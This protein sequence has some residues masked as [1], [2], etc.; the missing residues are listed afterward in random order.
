MFSRYSRLS[1]SRWWAVLAVAALLL[2][3]PPATA[4]QLTGAGQSSP[5]VWPRP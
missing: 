3:T 4:E 5:S 1:F 2:G